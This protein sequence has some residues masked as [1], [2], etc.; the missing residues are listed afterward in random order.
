VRFTLPWV[1]LNLMTIVEYGVQKYNVRIGL[2][3]LRPMLT[4]LS[5]A[6]H[7]I[8]LTPEFRR[9]LKSSLAMETDEE[10]QCALKNLFESYGHVFP[11]EVVLGGTFIQSAQGQVESD[12]D[13]RVT[14]DRL[15]L[16]LDAHIGGAGA[17]GGK[18]EQRVVTI[19]KAVF[20]CSDDVV[21]GD[22]TIQ[23]PK[24]W[25]ESVKDSKPILNVHIK[26]DR[27]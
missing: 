27:H 12:E 6:R 10:K 17:G 7:L 2:L 22:T 24:T 4:N 20:Q 21:G 3:S 15:R 9:D 26:P 13:I 1:D 11:L 18:L 8:E 5:V 16:S 14:K 19:K 25:I 23:D